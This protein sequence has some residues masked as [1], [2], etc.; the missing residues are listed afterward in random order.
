MPE[1]GRQDGLACRGGRV[2]ASVAVQVPYAQG[3]PWV[4][5]SEAVNR[6]LIAAKILYQSQTGLD[7]PQLLWKETLS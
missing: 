7:L 2:L 6:A 1:H 3:R 4:V 5:W